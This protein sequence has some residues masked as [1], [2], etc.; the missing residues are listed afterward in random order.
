[1]YGQATARVTRVGA[2][3]GGVNCETG[4]GQGAAKRCSTAPQGLMQALLRTVWDGAVGAVFMTMPCESP[5][6]DSGG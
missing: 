5:R 2:S 3:S 4:R 1:M 6:S